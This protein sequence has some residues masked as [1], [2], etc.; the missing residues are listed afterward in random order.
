MKKKVLGVR[1]WVLVA[2]LAVFTSQL[3]SPVFAASKRQT[4]KKPIKPMK[5]FVDELMAKM[6]LQ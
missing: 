1:C 2:V 3:V 4:D 6:T 5:E